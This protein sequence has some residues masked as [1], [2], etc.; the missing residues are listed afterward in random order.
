MNWVRDYIGLPFKTFGRDRSGV[1]CWGLVALIYRERYG[2][3]LP[4][5]LQDYAD[6]KDSRSLG[7]LIPEEAARDWRYIELGREQEGDV[8]VMRMR[9]VPMHTA[10]CLGHGRMIHV[11]EGIDAAMESYTGPAWASRLVG[12]YRHPDF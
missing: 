4:D 2:L 7:S 11:Y 6:E 8:L 10:L 1:D 12:I 9:G 5:Y 3:H